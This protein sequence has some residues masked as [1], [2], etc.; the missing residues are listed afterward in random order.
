MEYRLNGVLI[1]VGVIDLLPSYVSSVYMFYDPDYRFL[2]LGTYA[3]LREIA[4]GRLLSAVRCTASWPAALVILI[5][6]MALGRRVCPIF[7]ST[8]SD[9]TAR[10]AASC[11]TNAICPAQS[12]CAR[13]SSW[14]A[15]RSVCITLHSRVR[16]PQ[17][18][19]ASVA[20]PS[21]QRDKHSVF[22][23]DEA[24]L[25]PSTAPPPRMVED[26]SIR[27]M[28][29][30]LPHFRIRGSDWVRMC[31]GPMHGCN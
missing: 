17:W 27:D 19:P 29:A 23:G 13:K 15:T 20:I 5:G 14:Y 28:V 7:G 24:R 22:G 6:A 3:M 16:G 4:W 11:T 12:F 1:A 2:N 18:V 30:H 25:R 10:R 8:H 21:L 31:S 26:V 9:C